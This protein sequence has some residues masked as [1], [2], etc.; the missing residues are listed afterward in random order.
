MVTPRL[1]VRAPRIYPDNPH[2]RICGGPGSATTLVYPTFRRHYYGTQRRPPA[3][4]V[5]LTWA[6]VPEDYDVQLKALRR[7][8]DISQAGFA[9]PSYII[10][11][12]MW[13]QDDEPDVLLIDRAAAAHVPQDSDVREWAFLD[14]RVFISSVMAELGQAGV[15]LE[16]WR[17]LARSAR[18]PPMAFARWVRGP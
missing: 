3:T 12:G 15:H 16:R 5:P 6:S 17:N 18:P 1:P 7:H 4:P 9:R 2:V 11:A 14:K 8:L 13:P 10:I